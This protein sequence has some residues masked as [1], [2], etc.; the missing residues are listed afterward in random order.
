MTR[1]TP[2]SREGRLALLALAALLLAYTPDMGRGF[3]KDDFA[4]I[5]GS[6]VDSAADLLG[7]FGRHNGFYRPLVAASFAADARL[8]G[9]RPFGYAATNLLLVLAS[10][11]ALACLARALG[12]GPP[13]ALLAAGLWA[14]SPHGICWGVM[15]ISGRTSL[16]LTLC[17]LLAA[18]WL[19]RGRPV[20]AAVCA[21]LALLAKEEAVLLPAVLAGGVALGLLPA[22]PARAASSG[23]ARAALRTA[24]LFA[25]GLGAY[26]LLRAR[27]GAY[28]P[29]T[30][31]PFYRPTLDPA[32]LL[33]NAAEY[34]DRALTF[35]L[36]ALLVAAL[37]ARAWPRP[38]VERR[39]AAFFG[40][41]WLAGG[42]G[43]T[44]FLPVRSSLYA[45]FPA[46]GSALAAAALLEGLPCSAASRPAVRLRF[47]AALALVALV[48]LL[49]SRNLRLR[50]TAELS[51]HA[52]AATSEAAPLLASGATLVLH[53]AD[54]RVN[55]RA[56]FGTLA[57]TALR[58]HLGLDAVRVVIEPPL[59]GGSAT[60]APAAGQHRTVEYALI[61]GRLVPL[62]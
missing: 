60:G 32:A 24:L 50:R 59:P 11:A 56:A 44:L 34:A 16:L 5:A 23:R 15:W 42:Y 4:W 20:G 8:F 57:D 18:L 38:D 3:I 1:A 14:L 22:P 37:V 58:L 21:F 55:L 45:C 35:P 61:S 30:A 19:A 12:L 39:R 27:T 26:L 33:R 54:T 17:A 51:A 52:L 6:R 46:A 9:L 13:G 31:P 43:L 49:H 48:P 47:L 28:W 29:S 41:L 40:L 7:L 2:G 36:A 25:P 53:D 10:A 62:P